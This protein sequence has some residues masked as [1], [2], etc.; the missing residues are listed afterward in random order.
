VGTEPHDRVVCLLHED[1]IIDHV[2]IP[3]CRPDGRSYRL[4]CPPMLWPLII[5][6]RAS[7]R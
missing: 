6:R 3:R 1:G 7:S 5:R 2:P 4:R